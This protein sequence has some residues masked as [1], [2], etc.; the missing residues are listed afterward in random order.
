MEVETALAERLKDVAELRDNLL[1][2]REGLLHF[3]RP[4]FEFTRKTW[5]FGRLD[6]GRF[7]RGY[8]LVFL[9]HILVI[10]GQTQGIECSQKLAKFDQQVDYPDDE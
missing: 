4:Y 10:R 6:L 8:S 9:S 2:C 3:V 5:T 1:A 7:L